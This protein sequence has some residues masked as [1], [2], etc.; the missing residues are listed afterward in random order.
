MD[1]TLIALAT[2]DGIAYAA[3]VFM[4]AVGLTLI[5]GVLRVLNVA[6]GSFY[7]IGA[8]IAAGVGVY[9]IGAGAPGWIAYPL[10]VISACV[11][12]VALGDASAAAQAVPRGEN[13]GRGDPRLRAEIVHI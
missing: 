10:M 13:A 7:A 1:A 8:Y 5:F 9:L 11:V 4:V 6:H 12:G 3:M 2:F